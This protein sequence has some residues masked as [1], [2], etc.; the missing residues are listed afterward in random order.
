[1]STI[2]EF[3]LWRIQR[4]PAADTQFVA[5]IVIFPGVRIERGDLATPHLAPLPGGP[6]SAPRR[7]RSEDRDH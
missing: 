4:P 5:Q 6:D 3:P 1:M 2:L 7:R